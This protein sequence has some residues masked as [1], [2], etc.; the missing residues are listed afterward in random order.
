MK[1]LNG[2]FWAAML[3]FGLI[4][5]VAWVVENMYLNVF[6]YKMFHA[7]AA[8]ISAMVSA[9]AV[10]AA[11]TTIFMG[12]LSDRMGKRKAFLCGG[13]V[14]WG[15]SILAFGF[16]RL[17]VLSGWTATTAEACALA[18]DLVILLDC[19]MTFFGSTANDACYNAW[20]TD[21]GDETNRGKIEGF[22]AMMP[23][24]AIL[25]VF[26]G[27]MGFQ[28]DLQESWT[29]IFCIIG[30]VVL[31]IGLLGFALVEEQKLEKPSYGYW[32]TIVYS[33]RPRVIGENKGL[34]GTLAV[35]AVF[36]ISIQIFM[37]YLILYYEKTL[38]M[39]DYVLIMAPAIL[40]ASVVTALYGKVYDKK[41]FSASIVP[42]MLTLMAG[43][44]L[45]FVTTHTAAVFAGSLL[46]MCGYLM[47]MS[48]FGAKIRQEIPANRAGQFQG[49]RIIGQV[50]IPGVVGPAIGAWVL[51]NARQVL[52]NDGTYSFLPDANIF[53]AALIAAAAV[54][55][56]LLPVW[57]KR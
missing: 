10:A 40:L 12:A 28:L 53:L 54:C 49:V 45:L 55:L 57:K 46:M 21:R 23:L 44:V 19:L 13:Y 48:V 18:I 1:R 43:Y 34:Y 15:L 50:L 56:L 27:F 14:L 11:V 22:N 4:G 52:N 33:F 6:I 8:Q 35:F 3:I 2:K 30:G 42:C 7:S 37:P 31:A 51:R 38:G 16:I 24:V 26:G 5:Q 39:A 36:N 25:V 20:L 41:G 9:S 29:V 17:D 47:G 32:Q